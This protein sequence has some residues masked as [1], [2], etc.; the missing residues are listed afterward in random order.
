M[1]IDSNYMS[2]FSMILFLSSF[3][4]FINVGGGKYKK[5]PFV[6]CIVICTVVF[7]LLSAGY[8][9][10]NWFT[11]RGFDDSV[12]YHLRFGTEGAGIGEFIPLIVLFVC[13]QLVFIIAI[14]FYL[15]TI[16]KK[17]SKKW[18]IIYTAMGLFSVG[19][20]VLCNPATI[21]LTAWIFNSTSSTDF[22]LYFKT[23]QVPDTVKK[24]KN[25]IY[26][27]L[28]GLERNYFNDALFPGLM[29][30]LKKIEQ[31]SMSFTNIQQVAGTS[32]TMAGMVGSQCGLPLLTPF[33]NHEFFMKTFMPDVVCLGDILRAKDYHLEFMGGADTAFAGKGLFYQS[34]GFA[35]VQGAKELLPGNPDASYVNSWGLYD[36]TLYTLILNRIRELK[37]SSKPWGMF[38]INIG[39]HQPEGY[40]S[41]ECQGIQY[42][43]GSDKLLSAAQCTD[44]LLGKMYR[45]L[46][47]EGILDDTVVIFAS[48]HLAPVMVKPYN[49]L[50][51][52]ERHNFMMLT[53]PGVAAGVNDRKGSSLD[54]A[55]TLLNYLG[56]GSHAIGLGRDL[57]GEQPTLRESF[58]SDALLKAKI[59]SWRSII[60]MTFSGYP[61]LT[62]SLYVETKKQEVVTGNTSLRYPILINYT[63]E[64]KIEGVW[65]PTDTVSEKDV[66]SGAFYLTEMV[67]NNQLFLWVDR[68][69]N[70]STLAADL[71]KYREGHCFYNGSLAA[72]GSSGFISDAGATVNLIFDSQKG[73]STTR[74]NVLREN[75]LTKNMA[76]WDSLGLKVNEGLAKPRFVILAGGADALVGRSYVQ[77]TEFKEPGL[78]LTR[79]NYTLDQEYA[80]RNKAAVVYSVETLGELP[81]CDKKQ[82]PVQL[83]ALIKKYPVNEKFTPLM[84]A[85]VGNVAEQCGKGFTNLP[86]DIRLSELDGLPIG[87]PYIA[88]FDEGLEVKYEKSGA[89]DRAIAVSVEAAD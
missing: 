87:S 73:A 21:N 15:R 50:E 63:P 33:T 8:L 49:T 27:Y 61:T 75:L 54:I 79:V 43:D 14:I 68:C 44:Y 85:I 11:G 30:E 57:N 70:I 31:Q 6:I 24:P 65:Y 22:S 28:E 60:E 59:F 37:K 82:G 7:S 29:P 2:C 20:A 35:S 71:Q 86:Q 66:F 76:Q 17:S 48:D 47:E 23:A 69:R 19:A 16:I 41:R 40:I 26:F 72:E 3:A 32:W 89:R 1:N 67:S 4:F 10:A 53:G 81:I 25:V 36:D 78:F 88:L 80:L 13:I 12:F 9:V 42:G 56:Y 18:S 46:K 74:A 55:S 5:I 83:E 51:K 84:Y 45:M 38:S 58:S 52:A 62:D 34:H 64:G 39:T 77:G